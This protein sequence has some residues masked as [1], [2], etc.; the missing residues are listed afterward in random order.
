[1]VGEA[2]ERVRRSRRVVLGQQR[3]EHGHHRPAV[4]DDVVDGLHQDVPV[5]AAAD[6]RVPH[7]RSGGQV[8][9]GEAV[10]LGEFADLVGGDAGTVQDGEGRLRA[11]LQYGDHPAVGEGYEAGGQV[12]EEGE[13]A[14]G[15]G[16]EPVGVHLSLQGEQLLLDVAA[17]RGVVVDGVEVQALLERGQGEDVPQRRAVE[18]VHVGL[19]ERQRGEVAGRVAAV[20]ECGQPGERLDVVGAEGVDVLLG[21]H[22]LGPGEGGRQCVA[23]G[24]CGFG[25]RV[26]LQ[27]ARQA[28]PGVA[29]LAQLPGGVGELPGAVRAG[30]EAAEVVEEHLRC[31]GVEL[32]AGQVAQGAVGDAAVGH[33]GQVLLDR[34]ERGGQVPGVRGVGGCTRVHGH[35]EERGEPADGPREFRFEAGGRR[36]ELRLAA[37]A[38]E[39]DVREGLV[40]SEVASSAGEGDGERG[41]QDVVDARVELRGCLAQQRGRDLGTHRHGPQAFAGDGVVLVRCPSAERQVGA[42]QGP[43]VVRAV[44]VEGG[45]FQQLGPAPER[46]A[47]RG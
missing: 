1:M 43:A 10:P 22:P 38:L 14:G 18:G 6:E 32:A 26:E 37:V 21:E 35:R 5:G 33:P 19:G 7:Q 11:V 16:R 12:R 44:G 3:A 27:G 40:L 46:R 4:G 20:F 15:G 2:A 24:R 17:R 47:D 9:S 30:L 31:G 28:H 39:F 36:N 13:Q 8:E 45:A 29:P 25:D 42:G 23:S 41:Q 34:L